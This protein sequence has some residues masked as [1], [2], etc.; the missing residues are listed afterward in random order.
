[1]KHCWHN[2]NAYII[3]F[4]YLQV[5]HTITSEDKEILRLKVKICDFEQRNIYFIVK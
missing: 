2:F 4:I 1:M 3:L 5:I